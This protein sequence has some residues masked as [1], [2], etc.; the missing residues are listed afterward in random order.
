MQFFVRGV[1]IRA[2]RAVETA[3]TLPALRE[4]Y[5]E[6]L[7]AI[8]ARGQAADAADRLIGNPF[9]TAPNLARALGLTRQGAQYVLGTLERAG[10]LTPA[11]TEFRPALYVAG[12]VLT[13]LQRDD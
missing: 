2:Q 4:T 10:I 3:E 1:A 12:E 11:K 9:V 13:T 7:R 8:R 5:R 6:R